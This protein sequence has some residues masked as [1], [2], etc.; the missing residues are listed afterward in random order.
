MPRLDKTFSENDIFR[1]YQRYLTPK[2]QK[3][4]LKYFAN[5]LKKE[6]DEWPESLCYYLGEI[7]ELLAVAIQLS[8]QIWDVS[9]LMRKIVDQILDSARLLSIIPII[10]PIL[11][12]DIQRVHYVINQFHVNTEKRLKYLQEY[13]EMLS[14]YITWKCFHR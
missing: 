8:I 13:L 11:L 3:E 4:V 5:E 14:E 12:Q 6:I 2:E 10:G 1:I 9:K 7:I